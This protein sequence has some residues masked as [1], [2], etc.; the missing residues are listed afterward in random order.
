MWTKHFIFWEG[1]DIQ[2][3]QKERGQFL[4]CQQRWNEVFV[5]ESGFD[6]WWQ[7]I[8]IRNG[9]RS[10]RTVPGS[11]I[12]SICKAGGSSCKATIWRTILK[13]EICGNY[14]SSYSYCKDDTLFSLP[15]AIAKQYWP[16]TSDST[17]TMLSICWTLKKFRQSIR[18]PV[19]HLLATLIVAT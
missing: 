7:W 19:S 1:S 18:S 10:Q 4:V 8:L 3:C 11:V 5:G 9:R 16:L 17:T 12:G 13:L 14:G 15:F 6:V 2:P